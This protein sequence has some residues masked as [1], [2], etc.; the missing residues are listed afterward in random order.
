MF[1]AISVNNGP[2]YL[3]GVRLSR[4]SLPTATFTNLHYHPPHAYSFYYYLPMLLS[5]LALL[6]PDGT[7]SSK[8]VPS[9]ADK[10]ESIGKNE[11]TFT[12]DNLMATN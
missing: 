8:D 6:I 1:L 3:F 5:T 10:R 11:T 2:A 7:N 4:H 9:K 12:P